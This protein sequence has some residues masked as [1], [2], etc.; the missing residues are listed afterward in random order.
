MIITV[1]RGK[2]MIKRIV[3]VATVWLSLFVG[4]ACAAE[5]HGAGST[6]VTPILEKWAADYTTKT[7]DEIEYRSI[8]SGAGIAQI[9]KGER[10]FWRVRHAARAGRAG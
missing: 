9:K 5:T 2:Q 4:S 3:G 8:G 1:Y 10:G 7:G 6:F